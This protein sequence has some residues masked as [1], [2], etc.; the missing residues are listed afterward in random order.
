MDTESRTSNTNDGQDKFKPLGNM[1]KQIEN[2]SER[3]KAQAA[4]ANVA[5]GA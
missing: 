2:S 3:L 4:G 5:S 1:K